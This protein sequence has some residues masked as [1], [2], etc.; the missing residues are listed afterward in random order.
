MDPTHRASRLP[1]RLAGWAWATAGVVLVLVPLVATLL[2]RGQYRAL[3]RDGSRIST[4][5]E[6]LDRGDFIE[7]EP[8]VE[9]IEQ[10]EQS[11]LGASGWAFALALILYLVLAAI[12]LLCY[13]LL[14]WATARGM[15]WA[16]IAGTLL[17]A[18]GAGMVF[19]LW[20]LFAVLDWLPLTALR[21]NH[22]GLAIVAL[23]VAGCVLAWLPASNDYV[24]QRRA[25]ARAI[26]R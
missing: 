9:R 20:Q 6:H 14:S 23:H 1:L 2:L 19:Q 3:K 18:L 22:A 12:T 26:R 7:L 25:A 10:L 4:L 24:R 8:Y 11:V 15:N 13:V 21:A 16:R 5:I 17:A